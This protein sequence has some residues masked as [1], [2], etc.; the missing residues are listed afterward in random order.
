MRGWVVYDMLSTNENTEKYLIMDFI[1]KVG[2][3]G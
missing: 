2:Y 3:L 1:L